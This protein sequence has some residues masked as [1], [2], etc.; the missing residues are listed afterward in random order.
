MEVY[1][2]DRPISLAIG[3]GIDRFS[4]QQLSSLQQSLADIEEEMSTLES[5][6]NDLHALKHLI[7]SKVHKIGIGRF[8]EDERKVLYK[9]VKETPRSIA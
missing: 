2:L 9:I 3:I 6:L 5:R 1:Q 4:G 8:E 7:L